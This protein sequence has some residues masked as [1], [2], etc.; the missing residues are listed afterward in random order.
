MPLLGSKV[1]YYLEHSLREQGKVIKKEKYIGTSIPKDMVKIKEEFK[2]ELQNELFKKLNNI[3]EN[4][5]AE[6]KK[7]PESARQKEKEEL[8][9]AFTYNTNAIEGST[10]T[11]EEAMSIIHD[12]FAPNKPL[13]EIKETE[14]H[15]R[16]FL[17]MLGKKENPTKH[18]LLTSLTPEI[19]AL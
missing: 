16:V 4:F 2:K 1:Y 18:L 9:I 19:S 6:W 8:A 11:L 17:A 10:I 5:Q 13:R 15:S 14:A 7:I 12:N 3:K